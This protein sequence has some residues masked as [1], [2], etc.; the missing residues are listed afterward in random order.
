VPKGGRPRI[1]AYMKKIFSN[2]PA[3][4]TEQ[5]AHA[6]WQM[7]KNGNDFAQASTTQGASIGL[8]LV[9]LGMPPAI[10]NDSVA[11]VSGG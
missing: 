4:S 2:R 11:T 5:S 3:R 6:F 9:A 10:E 8:T 7:L 1:P